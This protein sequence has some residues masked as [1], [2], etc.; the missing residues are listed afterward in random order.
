MDDDLVELDTARA[1][2]DEAI[3]GRQKLRTTLPLCSVQ[4]S[5]GLEARENC[6]APDRPVTN[7]FGLE[8]GRGSAN[9]PPETGGQRGPERLG[10]VGQQYVRGGG[11]RLPADTPRQDLGK[12]GPAPNASQVQKAFARAT[13]PVSD[14]AENIGLVSRG[15]QEVEVIRAER[16]VAHGLDAR[17]PMVLFQGE[18]AEQRAVVDD[19]DEVSASPTCP[20]QPPRSQEWGGKGGGIEQSVP[21]RC[22]LT[23]A[24]RCL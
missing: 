17:R 12:H 15:G 22:P 3:E 2:G 7:P 11:D 5:Q 8:A 20:R 14:E 6:R 21:L 4:V 16:G 24:P 10:A 9:L 13:E 19:Q 23:E 18:P 1:P